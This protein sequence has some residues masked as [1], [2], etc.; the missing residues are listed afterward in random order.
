MI[1]ALAL[2][3]ITFDDFAL[4][5]VIRLVATFLI[6]EVQCCARNGLTHNVRVHRA[7]VCEGCSM[8]LL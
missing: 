4:A 5:V 6:G 8:W 1:L 2:F 3:A 7:S